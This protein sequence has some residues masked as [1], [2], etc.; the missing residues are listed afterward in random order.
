MAS[1][2]MYY[3]FIERTLSSLLFI[4]HF[5]APVDILYQFFIGEV[6]EYACVKVIRQ[7]GIIQFVVQQSDITKGQLTTFQRNIHI[8]SRFIV[9][10]GTGTIDYGFLYRRY[11]C[12]YLAQL[13]YILF[14]ESVH[15]QFSVINKSVYTPGINDAI[16]WQNVTING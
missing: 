16:L 12:Q 2:F 5:S 15:C 11:R 3:Q 7:I 8:R 13:L 9:A 14:T 1:F 4:K 6:C 10:S